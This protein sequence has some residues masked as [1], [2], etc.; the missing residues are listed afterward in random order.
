M[1]G[2]SGT[3][4]L[5]EIVRPLDENDVAALAAPPPMKTPSITTIKHSHHQLAQLLAQG[6]S[7]AEASLMTGYSQTRISILKSDPA[8][9]DLLAYYSSQRD[10]IFVNV[11]ER[12]KVLGLSTLDELT[13]RLEESGDRFSA[14]ELMELAKLT[15]ID[16]R[17]SPG[18]AGAASAAGAAG[19]MNLTVNFV[20]PPEAAPTITIE[21]VSNDGQ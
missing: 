21:G 13:R 6:R 19:G 7:N 11:L 15:L 18:G 10:A 5:W 9:C 3:A 2:A 16:G 12:M 20:S 4:V 17:V 1:S 14:R 8:F